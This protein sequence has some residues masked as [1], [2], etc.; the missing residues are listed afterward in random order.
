MDDES[1]LP[2]VISTQKR[3]HCTR[4]PPSSLPKVKKY[5]NAPWIVHIRRALLQ[6]R[7][8]WISWQK[9]FIVKGEILN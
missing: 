5:D 1:D 9:S 4:L 8:K 2:P 3:K 7:I 6:K